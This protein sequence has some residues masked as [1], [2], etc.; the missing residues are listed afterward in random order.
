MR[1]GIESIPLDLNYELKHKLVKFVT[2][3]GRITGDIKLSDPS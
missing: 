1:E 3:L 2:I